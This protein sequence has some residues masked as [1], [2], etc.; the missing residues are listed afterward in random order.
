MG[1]PCC[2]SSRMAEMPFVCCCGSI[3][4][5]EALLTEKLCQNPGLW[6]AADRFNFPASVFFP[7]YLRI[8]I[9]EPSVYYKE[10][11]FPEGMLSSLMQIYKG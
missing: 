11:F 5:L 2:S 7:V 6:T 10:S 1:L 8:L 4:K 3:F 9:L